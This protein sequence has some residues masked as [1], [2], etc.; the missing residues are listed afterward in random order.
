MIR[1]AGWGLGVFLAGCESDLPPAAQNLPWEVVLTGTNFCWE[2]TDPGRDG[3]LGTVDDLHLAPP[4]RLP[5]N[6]PTRVLL[7]SRDYLYTFELTALQIKQ[8]AIPD[9]TY[10][11]EFNSGKP[12]ESEFRGD[13]FCNNAHNALSGTVIIQSWRDYRRWQAI[14]ETEQ[15]TQR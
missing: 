6:I 10:F 15:Q 12:G 14:A 1:V 5:A 13:Q 3:K 4:L 7:R 9:L 2:I 11:V 8:I